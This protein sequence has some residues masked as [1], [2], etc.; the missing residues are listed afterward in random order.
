MFPTLNIL[1]T[2]KPVHNTRSG[3]FACYIPNLKSF[4]DKLL[5]LQAANFR[6]FSLTPLNV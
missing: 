2:E 4:K 5:F 1:N 6:I 3:D